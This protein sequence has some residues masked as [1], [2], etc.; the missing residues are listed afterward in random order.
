[1]TQKCTCDTQNGYISD[2]FK[3][4]LTYGKCVGVI[5]PCLSN[6]DCFND[7]LCEAG[8]CIC[9]GSAGDLCLK[10]SDW[11]CVEDPLDKIDPCAG[12]PTV[13][14]KIKKK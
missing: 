10:G 5:E 7:Q 3:P 4:S 14:V 6:S 8:W 12:E 2:D 9:Q 11:V 13:R 1:M